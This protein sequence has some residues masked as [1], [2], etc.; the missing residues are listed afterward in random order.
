MCSRKGKEKKITQGNGYEPNVRLCTHT[1]GDFV[2]ADL[3]VSWQQ[4]DRIDLERS[5][6]FRKKKKNIFIFLRARV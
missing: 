6:F 5:V 4:R 2:P 3:I 1:Y